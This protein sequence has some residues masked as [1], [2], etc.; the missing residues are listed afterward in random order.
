MPFIG[1][2]TVDESIWNDASWHPTDL[3]VSMSIQSMSGVFA[4]IRKQ[5]SCFLVGLVGGL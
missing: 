5:V 2:V 1:R 4:G 3:S